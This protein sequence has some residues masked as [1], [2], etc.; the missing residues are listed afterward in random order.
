MFSGNLVV[1]YMFLSA[2]TSAFCLWHRKIRH[3]TSTYP[4]IPTQTYLPTCLSLSDL[5]N[6]AYLLTKHPS[7]SGVQDPKAYL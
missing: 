5:Q 3:N 4:L 6:E 2:S 7:F 1:Y